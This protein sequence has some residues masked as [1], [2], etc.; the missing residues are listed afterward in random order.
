MRYFALAALMTS[1]VALAE[2]ATIIKDSDLR[3]KPFA[4]ASVTGTLKNKTTVDLQGSKS[5]WAQVQTKDGQN[6]WV[7]LFNVRTGSGQSGDTGLK[8]MLSMFKTGSSGTT[9]SN[10][11]K[12]ADDIGED[13]TKAQPNPAE[14]AK[15]DKFKAVGKDANQAAKQAKLSAKTIDY[16][17]GAPK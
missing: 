6:G 3:D 1:S 12:G 5:A 16:L 2:P 10:G 17:P 14:V 13:L 15:L 8:S 4:D 11:V 7:P 9:V